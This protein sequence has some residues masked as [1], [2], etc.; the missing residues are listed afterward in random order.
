M[1][2]S[3]LSNKISDQPAALIAI[4][5]LVSAAA[6][7][8][9]Q[10]QQQQQQHK[11]K[12]TT[13]TKINSKIPSYLSKEAMIEAAGPPALPDRYITDSFTNARSQ[14]IFTIHLPRADTSVPPKAMFILIHGTAEHCCRNGYIGLYESLAKAGVDVYSMD[15]HGNGRSD[16]EPRGYTETFDH[17]VND[18]VEYIQLVRSKYEK[19]QCPPLVLMGDSLGGCIAVVTALK[20]GNGKS[21]MS[22][23]LL[24]PALGVDMNLELKIQKVRQLCQTLVVLL[25]NH[26]LISLFFLFSSFCISS[27]HQ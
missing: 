2:I 12:T 1:R 6:A 17:Y 21:N 27:L 18:T 14:S 20:M 23:I 25:H 10:Q 7:L 13:T 26:L 5:T 15:T 19:D 22:L 11:K 4:I 3:T 9:F 8:A 24:S 16:G